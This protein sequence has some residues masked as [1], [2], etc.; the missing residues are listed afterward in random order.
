MSD[1]HEVRITLK[2]VYHQQQEQGRVL[3]Q[4]SSDLKRYLDSHDRVKEQVA[5]HEDRIRLMERKIWQ[6][7]GVAAF[8]GT[9]GG[10]I[11]NMMFK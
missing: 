6:A 2:E 4:M 8:L 9:V 5:D 3:L 11:V 10:V 7:S 1:E